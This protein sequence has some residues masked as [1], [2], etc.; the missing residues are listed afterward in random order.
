MFPVSCS[1]IFVKHNME[2]F[3]L[4][5]TTTITIIV[6]NQSPK[7][8]ALLLSHSVFDRYS[9]DSSLLL[10]LIELCFESADASDSAPEFAL[11]VLKSIALR[12]DV[13][14]YVRW[15]FQ[16]MQCEAQRERFSPLIASV[17]TAASSQRLRSDQQFVICCD[18]MKDLVPKQ[19]RRRRVS[20][21]ES[22]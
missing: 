3:P 7:S 2:H 12:G 17:I 9:A 10:H 11:H 19:R 21:G 20:V 13:I 22:L 6:S 18:P 5:I 16:R 14:D 1:H 15:V 4:T 8:L